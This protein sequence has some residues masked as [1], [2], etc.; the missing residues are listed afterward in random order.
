MP[1]WEP[2]RN[3]I[4]DEARERLNEFI[5]SNGGLP[6]PPAVRKGRSGAA[7]SQAATHVDG[8]ADAAA[9]GGGGVGKIMGSEVGLD[10]ENEEDYKEEEEEEEEEEDEDEEEAPPPPP[11]HRRL[12]RVVP[13]PE[14][15]SWILLGSNDFVR[16]APLTYIPLLGDDDDAVAKSEVRATTFTALEDS[17]GDRRRRPGVP[18]HASPHSL[19]PPHHATHYH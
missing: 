5:R 13:L 12:P 16:D 10:V 7:A 14:S 11:P 3:F 17:L 8:D 4:G 15:R 2:T 18:R 9:D 1:T 6:Y 19:R